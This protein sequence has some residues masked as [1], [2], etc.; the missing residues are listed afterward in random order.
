MKN[1]TKPVGFTYK[2]TKQHLT[3]YQ[4]YK[5][6]AIGVVTMVSRWWH[7]KVELFAM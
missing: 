3:P 7:G 2:F 5:M 1:P 6:A 4:T